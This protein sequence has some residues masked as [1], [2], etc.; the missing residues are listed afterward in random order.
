MKTSLTEIFQLLD[1]Q[2]TGKISADNIDLDRIDGEILLIIKPL[3]VEMENYDEDLDRDEFIDS[4]IG[5]LSQKDI[6]TRNIVLNHSRK[7]AI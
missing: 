4:A 7:M 3:L 6:N 2:G 1:S 5:L